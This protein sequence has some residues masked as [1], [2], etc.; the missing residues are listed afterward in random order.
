[1]TKRLASK[2]KIDRRYGVNLWGRAKS[3]V[4]K[5]SYKPGQHGPTARAGAKVSPYGLQLAAKQKMRGYYGF[6]R[7]SQFRR[8]YKE[9][10]RLKGDTGENFVGLLESRLDV[11]VYNLKFAPTIFAARQFVNHGHVLVNGKRV[12]IPSYLLK[13]GDTIQVKSASKEM[14]MIAEAQSSGERDIPDY[15]QLDTKALK[16]TFLRKPAF[17]DIP[18]P[19]QMS[20]PLIVEW[21][22]RRI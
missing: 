9:A 12:N 8:F 14:N 21:Y 5:R 10:S 1:M 16:G 13:D 15:M 2:F 11:A 18:Y 7:E 17:A 4:S 3:P 19:T 20:P 22:A 6:I